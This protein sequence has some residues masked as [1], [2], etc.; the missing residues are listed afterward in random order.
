MTKTLRSPRRRRQFAASLPGGPRPLRNCPTI[1]PKRSRKK[2]LDTYMNLSR[3]CLYSTQWTLSRNLTTLLTR[4]SPRK[5]R[6]IDPI[7]F[8]N[9]KKSLPLSS[10]PIYIRKIM[11][12]S[13]NGGGNPLYSDSPAPLSASAPLTRTRNY[14]HKSN[15]ERRTDSARS[16][17]REERGHAHSASRPFE[18]PTGLQRRMEGGIG[19]EKHGRQAARGRRRREAE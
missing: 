6:P 9:V 8:P 19:L 1:H 11:S 18:M 14:E 10:H 7:T 15:N 3:L 4:E 17:D 2:W 13:L 5:Q 12:T 16:T